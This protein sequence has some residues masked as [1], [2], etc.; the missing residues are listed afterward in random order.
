MSNVL[1]IAAQRFDM[2]PQ[3]LEK[4][5]RATVVPKECTPDQFVAF[6]MVANEYSLNPILK[7]IYAFPAKSGGIQPIVAIDGWIKIINRHPEFDGLEYEDNLN[8]Q[9]KLISITCKMHRKDRSRPV[10]VTEYLSECA[11][12]TDPWRQWPARML[13]HKATIQC[14]RLAF[15]FSGIVD[16][17]EYE[18]GVEKPVSGEHMVIDDGRAELIAQLEEA[19]AGGML[20]YADAFKSL[21]PEQRKLL[22]VEEHNR[23]KGMAEHNQ[24][25]IDAGA[26]Q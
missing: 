17:D 23:L 15:G 10:T 11:R 2:E 16:P 25:I 13:R 21:T 26:A 9:G 14:A 8:D 19:A 1:A 7:E 4:T 24:A 18:R 6:L 12:N 5:L 20:A 22:G 3:Q